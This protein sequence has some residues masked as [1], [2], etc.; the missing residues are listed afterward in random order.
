MR[1]CCWARTRAKWLIPFELFPFTFLLKAFW[2]LLLILLIL[3]NNY[4]NL[5]IFCVTVDIDEVLLDENKDLWDNSFRV[6][7]LCNS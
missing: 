3:L 4:K 1:C 5:F 6:I 2:F 7:I